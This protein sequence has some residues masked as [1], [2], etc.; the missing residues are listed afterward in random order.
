[1]KMSQI[2]SKIT[3]EAIALSRKNPKLNPIEDFW[4]NSGVGHLWCMITFFILINFKHIFVDAYEYILFVHM[5]VI[6]S[7]L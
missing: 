5:K 2:C 1:M 3:Q 7:Y 4:K 6:K